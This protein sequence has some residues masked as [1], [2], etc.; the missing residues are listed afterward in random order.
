VEFRFLAWSSFS[1][2]SFLFQTESRSATQTVVQWR[3]LSS[4]QPPPPRI[5]RFSYLSLLSS[6]DYRPAPPCPANFC[7]FSR[8]RVSPCCPGLSRT[9]GLQQP[10]H[11][12]L[13]KC[14]DLRPN[15]LNKR[16]AT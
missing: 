10:Y 13:S 3:D 9:P 4:L 1:P 11:L 12:S 5:K 6:W 8:D 14:E 16:K 15:Y 7:V 2:E